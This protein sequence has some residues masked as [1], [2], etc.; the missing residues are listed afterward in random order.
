MSVQFVIPL[1]LVNLIRFEQFLKPY[2][3]VLSREEEILRKLNNPP[4]VPS[5]SS[6]DEDSLPVYRFK[7]LAKHNA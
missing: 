4:I 1:Y 2:E 5:P 7:F 3:D 6:R